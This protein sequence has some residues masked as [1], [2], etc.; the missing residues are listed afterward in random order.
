[1]NV[2]F[3][4]PRLEREIREE[5]RKREGKPLTQ[6]DL[7]S[8]KRL[9][10]D[11][12]KIIDLSGLEHAINLE[13]LCLPDTKNWY[14][15]DEPGV[16]CNQVADLS[17][18]AELSKLTHLNLGYSRITDISPLAGLS[19]LTKLDLGQNNVAD[20]SALAH[21]PKLTELDMKECS[22]FVKADDLAN[23]PAL[24]TLFLG[25]CPAKV[26][27]DGLP[28]ITGLTTLHLFEFGQPDLSLLAVLKNL[29]FL[30]VTSSDSLVSLEG[31]ATL[32]KLE[33]LGFN[34]CESLANL[35]EL[36]K[37][38]SLKVLSIFSCR[39]LENMETLGKMT[40]LEDLNLFET[41]VPKEQV[42]MMKEALI[43][44]KIARKRGS[45]DSSE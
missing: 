13:N 37:M 32:T 26:I 42:E 23:L 3:K 30:F 34:F 29:K 19:E 15:I 8:L 11:E 41:N 44:A 33:T 17:P 1:M 21:L 35:D 45:V 9:C 10:V 28:K 5:L 36:A 43:A 40:W 39:S 22:S 20:F 12:G 7:A 31:V 24:K 18:L 16:P 27:A 38:T 14:S 2:N 6:Q 4:C 25:K